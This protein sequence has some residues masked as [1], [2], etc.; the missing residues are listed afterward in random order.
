MHQFTAH[1]SQRDFLSLHDETVG[2]MWQNYAPILAFEHPFLL[3]AIISIAALHI[4]KIQPDRQDMADV[5]RTYYNA[6]ISQHRHAVQDMS[7]DN[8]E[9]VWIS[10]VLIA[11]PAF[12]LLQNT[13]Y[14]SYSPPLQLFHILAGNIPVFQH[15]RPLIKP[16]SP[17]LCIL[18]AKPN[19]AEF[20]TEARNEVYLQPFAQL[21]TW[22]APD[23]SSDLES[24]Q[25]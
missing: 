23:E 22:R 17:V 16:E 13:E 2:N 14:I 4:A 11:L 8:A 21:R 10:T 15:G 1:T 9:A 20:L 19:L 12:I 6:A 5:H 7:A 25:V 24:L 18:A 3:S